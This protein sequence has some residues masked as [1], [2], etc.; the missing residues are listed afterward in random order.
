MKP[1]RDWKY[2]YVKRRL[3]DDYV[4]RTSQKLLRLRATISSL[5]ERVKVIEDYQIMKITGERPK[6]E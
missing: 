5:E 3:Y 1:E 6:R 4:D 2:T